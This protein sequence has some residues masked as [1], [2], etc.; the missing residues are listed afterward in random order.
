MRLRDRLS[1]EMDGAIKSMYLALAISFRL[2]VL[3]KEVSATLSL[4]ER[5]SYDMNMVPQVSGTH[6]STWA[7]ICSQRIQDETDVS[8]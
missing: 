5:S 7:N 4:V 1:L 2:L 6:T 8:S 3:K